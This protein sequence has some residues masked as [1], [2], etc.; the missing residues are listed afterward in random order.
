MPRPPK[1]GVVRLLRYTTW[2]CGRLERAIIRFLHERGFIARLEEMRIYLRNK[3]WTQSLQR[4]S[5]R[6]IIQVMEVK[7]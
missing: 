2:K 3:N 7:R 4:L 6:R 5:R 1:S